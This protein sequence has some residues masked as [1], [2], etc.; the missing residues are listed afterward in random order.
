M[1]SVGTL[2]LTPKS[3]AAEGGRVARLRLSWTHPVSWRKLR[4]VTLRLRL[5]DESVARVTVRPR[6]ERLTAAG[7]VAL[8]RRATRLSH[9]GQTV[10][11]RLALRLDESLAGRR[12]T[13]DVEAVDTRGREQVE[14]D[15][16]TIRVPR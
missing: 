13:A 2:A 5:G 3:L 1:N 7:A 11:A 8:V 9:D 10:T 6:G 4:T 16:A 15:A 12:L 14:R